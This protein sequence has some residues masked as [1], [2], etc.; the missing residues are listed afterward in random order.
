MQA[1]SGSSNVASSGISDVDPLIVMIFG[2]VVFTTMLIVVDIVMVVGVVVLCCIG[3]V[4][5]VIV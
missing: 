5:F 4:P 1:N 3:A 2:F